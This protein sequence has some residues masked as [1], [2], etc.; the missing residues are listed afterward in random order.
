MH[1]PMASA[2][3]EA[4]ALQRPIRG[5]AERQR[6]RSSFLVDVAKAPLRAAERGIV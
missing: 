2:N 6:L 5:A 1:N 3:S 4:P